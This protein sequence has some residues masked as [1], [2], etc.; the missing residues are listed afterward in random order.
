[1]IK[2]GIILE[3]PPL[4]GARTPVG[5]IWGGSG[6]APRA[7]GQIGIYVTDIVIRAM[8]LSVKVMSAII[9]SNKATT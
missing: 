1:M 9:K 2:L 4:R 6:G 7:G 3:M 8:D 5:G